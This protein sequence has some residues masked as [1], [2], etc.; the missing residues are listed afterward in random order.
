MILD[1][2]D[3]SFFLALATMSCACFSLTIK[4]CFESK[5]DA[6]DQSF[7]WNCF[8]IKVHRNVGIE[9]RNYTPRQN[10]DDDE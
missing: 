5:C 8:K 2:F 7:L 9:S 3:S 10:N 4:T 1:T 6:V